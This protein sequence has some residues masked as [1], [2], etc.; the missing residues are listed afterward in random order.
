[1]AH[2]ISF[3]V[4]LLELDSHLQ[5]GKNYLSI[6]INAQNKHPLAFRQLNVTKLDHLYQDVSGDAIAQAL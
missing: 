1:M 5:I 2:L 3:L 6:T 4:V